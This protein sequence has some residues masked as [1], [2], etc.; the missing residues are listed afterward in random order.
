MV[1]A[2]YLVGST[3]IVNRYAPKLVLEREGASG[4][5]AFTSSWLGAVYDAFSRAGRYNWIVVPVLLVVAG[6]LTW[7]ERHRD[8]T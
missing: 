3:L 6:V 2:V 7:S 4:L 5:A 1:V 8:T